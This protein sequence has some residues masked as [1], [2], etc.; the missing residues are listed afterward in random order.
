MSTSVPKRPGKQGPIVYKY[1]ATEPK[2]W[3][4]LSYT[5]EMLEMRPGV[6]LG[7]HITTHLA[8]LDFD[9]WSELLE[10]V[11]AREEASNKNFDI[12]WVY[13]HTKQTVGDGGKVEEKPDTIFVNLVH[14][15]AD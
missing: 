6:S 8:K 9:G 1:K 15:A 12:G 5:P 10:F 3:V 14:R 2:K 7:D 13:V 4:S 11:T